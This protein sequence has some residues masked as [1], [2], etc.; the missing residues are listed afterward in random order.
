LPYTDIQLQ[1]ML[2]SY[3]WPFLRI[4][5]LFL[6]APIFGAA[7]FPVRARV[8]LAVLVVAL[9]APLLPPMEQVDPVGAGGILL[10]AQQIL[11]GVSMGFILQMT[12]GAVVIAGQSLAM[13]MGLGFAMSVDP[14]NG[15]QV[16]V[17]SQLYVILSTL[18]FLAIDA[19]LVLIQILADSF[20]LIPVGVLSVDGAFLMNVVL[21][22]S[23][24]FAGALLLALPALTAVLLINISFGVITRAAPQLNIFAVGFPVTIGVGFMFIFLSMPS[25]FSMLQEFFDNSLAHILWLLG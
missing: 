22:A 11:I 1:A 14:Q 13:T 24:M 9:I 3:Y 21:W 2:Q 5:G 4:S 18:I 17:L 8:L 23:Q 19:H 7:S 25:M 20:T 10:S 12:F 6:A 16:P 15:V